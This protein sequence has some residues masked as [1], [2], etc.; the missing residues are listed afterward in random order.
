MA[1]TVAF[2]LLGALLFS[3]FLAPVLASL[4]YPKGTKEWHNPLMNFLTRM[5]TRGLD[6]AIRWRW[7]TVGMALASL[8]GVLVA[9][10]R[11]RLGIPAAS[12]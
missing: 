1:W 8:G 2:A 3:M 11:H 10:A 12:G 9:G 6:L 7:I 5:Y 4:V